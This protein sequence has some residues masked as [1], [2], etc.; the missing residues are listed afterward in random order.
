[1]PGFAYKTAQFIY[2]KLRIQKNIGLNRIDP[3]VVV[4]IYHR[5]T[6]LSDDPQLLAV[7]PENFRAHMHY[8]KEN[9]PIVRF[10]DDWSKV[11]KPA[12]VITFDD[13]YADNALEALPIIEEVGVPATFFIITGTIDTKQEFWSDE[14]ERIVLGEWD[15][16]DR[17]R[18]TDK[19]FGRIWPTATPDER[20]AL[21]KEIHPIMK[22][23]DAGRR[24]RWLEQL[25]QWARADEGFRDTHRVMTIEEL[26][27]LAQSKWV[28]IGAHTVTHTPLSSLSVT[29]QKEEILGSRK[30]L[31][32][33]LGREINVFSYPFGT[34]RDYTRASRALCKESGYI[35]AAANYRGQVHKWTDPYQLPR[36]LVRNWTLDTFAAKIKDFWVQ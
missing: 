13:G 17:F 32:T 18:L 2:T 28:T 29:A 35:K 1:M 15:F 31:E 8:L 6:T 26:R 7:T 25:R 23:V 34:K 19:S 16:S 9:F 36:Q 14:L 11:T 10:E 27:R 21:Y 33:W 30:Q 5:V 4:L 12:V 20:L 3:P 24:G 22:K